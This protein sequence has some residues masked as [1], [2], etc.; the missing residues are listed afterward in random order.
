MPSNAVYSSARW[1]KLRLA[2]LS[3]EPQCRL[4]KEQGRLR[5]SMVVDHI[6][7]HKDDAVLMW[8][9]W[10]LRGLCKRCHDS[11]TATTDNPKS[12]GRWKRIPDVSKPQFPVAVICGPAASG[13]TTYVK[14]HMSSNDVVIDVDHIASE[15]SGRPVHQVDMAK[16]LQPTMLERNKRLMQLKLSRADKGW[17][18]VG[19]SRLR[20]RRKWAQLLG[21]E[22]IVM[23]T[24][25]GTCIERIKQSSRI[26]KD[27]AIRSV[28]KW[29]ADYVS[30][31]SD[32]VIRC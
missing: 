1:R 3:E 20:D 8:A 24:D 19:G 2:V 29:W 23:E 13:K 9:R 21:G 15:L 32:T 16:W 26:A 27:S 14:E 6:E 10:N 30:D 22:I 31:Y 12:F 11:K 17:L 18:I 7:A 25:E 5:A 4:C 28:A